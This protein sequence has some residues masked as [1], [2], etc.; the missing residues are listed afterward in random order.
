MSLSPPPSPPTPPRYAVI[1]AG[2]SGLSALRNLLGADISAVAFEAAADLG[3]VWNYASPS[4]R[5][6]LNTHLISS[7]RLTEFADFPLDR[8]LPPYLHHS[9]ALTYFRDYARHFGLLPH[10][11]YGQAVSQVERR[12]GSRPWR[13]WLHGGE[14][15]DFEGVVVASGHHQIPQWPEIPGKF[16]GEWLH[17]AQ[18]KCP[19]Q[20]HDRRVLIIG[21]GN[22]A[23]DIAVDAAQ[24]AR[25]C[26]LS[27]R[28]G[29]HFLPKFIR[30]IPADVWGEWL[31]RWRV[32]L[33]IRRLISQ[34]ISR[35]A[36]GTPASFG[37][38][39][40]DHRP[41][42]CHPLV[43][44]QLLYQVG[45]GHITPC[46]P[47]REFTATGVVF[48]NGQELPVDMVICATGYQAV[49]PFI[50]PARLNMRDGLPRLYLHAFHPTDD[51]L[52]MAG[53]IQPDSGQWG[54]TDLQMK[55]MARYLQLRDQ[56]PRRVAW[57]ADLKIRNLSDL[58]NGIRYLDTPR[59]RLE[60]EH[61]SY[62]RTL[63]K[64]LDR[65]H[66]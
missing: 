44:S 28:R 25:H 47:V 41:W 65:L 26:W 12:E 46:G 22:S 64:I 30:G 60:V 10:I 7:Q 56:A 45:H 23:C 29:Y 52:Y 9:Q 33:G 59:H 11:R 63:T 50:E 55:I 62:R 48:A 5:V 43:N 6:A 20:L 2:P 13:V 57:F 66:G 8:E 39:P 49:F 21:A 3:G 38:P 17:S 37:F 36:L 27:W 32:P 54:L 31:L 16:E 53:M 14:C 40:P 58:G 1:G 15:H 34:S 24:H 51:S 42:E 18:Y 4:G 19:A 61:F 35:I